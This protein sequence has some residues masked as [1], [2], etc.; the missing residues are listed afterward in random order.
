[1]DIFESLENLNV[2]EKCFEDIINKIEE[3]I[4]DKNINNIPDNEPVAMSWGDKDGNY[5]VVTFKNKK[6][7]L[8]DEGTNQHLDNKTFKSRKAAANYALKKGY[9][10]NENNFS[11]LPQNKFEEK[12]NKELEKDENKPI[13]YEK[14]ESNKKNIYDLNNPSSFERK[15]KIALARYE[16]NKLKGMSESDEESNSNNREDEPINLERERIAKR[17]QELMNMGANVHQTSNGSALI[18]DPKIVKEFNELKER[19][20]KLN[21]KD[22]NSTDNN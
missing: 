2:S 8:N 6:S 7:T 22:D 3:A 21:S 12:I 20:K 15:M 11:F 17:V 18:G 4:Q 19:L 13:D 14:I 9:H 5:K 16:K 10:V 1:M